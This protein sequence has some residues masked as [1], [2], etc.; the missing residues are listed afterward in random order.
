VSLVAHSR[1]YRAVID[2]RSIPGAM[3]SGSSDNRR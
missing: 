2:A 3:V 1:P